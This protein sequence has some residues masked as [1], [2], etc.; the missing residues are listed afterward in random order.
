VQA[1]IRAATLQDVGA[2]ALLL[3][4]PP[5]GLRAVVADESAALRMARA[6]FLARGS[7]MSFEHASVAESAGAVVGQIVRFPGAQWPGL[8]VRAGL[9]M[10]RVA[11]PRAAFRLVWRGPVEDALVAPLSPDV[12]YI[13]SLAVAPELRGTGIGALLLRVALAEAAAARLRAVALDVARDNAG[14]IRF[15]VREGFAILSERS[16]P[17]RRGLPAM[18]SVRM[19][20]A[21]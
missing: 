4:E 17:A 14:A 12:L 9:A 13:M 7:A 19:E 11:G 8:R 3:L 15:Y 18:A 2:A 1:R 21:V 16:T 20:R 6:A 5:G 10:L